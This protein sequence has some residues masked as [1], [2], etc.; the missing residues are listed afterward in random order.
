[1]TDLDSMLSVLE[2]YKP[3]DPVTLTLWR[4]G[5]TRKQ[6]VTLGASEE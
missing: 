5:K 6:P 1:M 2:R 3:G 4:A